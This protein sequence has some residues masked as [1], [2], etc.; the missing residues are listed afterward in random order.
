MWLPSS[1]SISSSLFHFAVR[2]D[3]IVDP[4]LI[5]PEFQPTATSASQSSSVSPERALT[6]VAYPRD[7][8]R[9]KTF[10]ARLSVPA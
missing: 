4:T 3:R 9:S 8:A 1:A 10:L 2:S 5:W 6:T 7:F